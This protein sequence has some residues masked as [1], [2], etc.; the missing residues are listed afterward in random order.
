MQLQTINMKHS[1]KLKSEEL[2][3]QSKVRHTN[4]LFPI[5]KT[6]TT[7]MQSH[8]IAAKINANRRVDTQK[9][10]FVTEH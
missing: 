9:S 2:F 1:M 3:F 8:I 7:T 6:T 10:T 4:K 5:L